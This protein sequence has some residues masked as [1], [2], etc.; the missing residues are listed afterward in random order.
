M[1]YIG[2]KPTV[3]NF[4]ICDAISVVNGQAAYTMQVGSVNVI[5]ESANHMIVSLNG[6]IQKPNS[7]FTVSGSTITF[8]SNLATG[9]VIDFIQ[10]LGNVLDLGVPSD[11]TVTSAKLNLTS[12]VGIGESSPGTLLDIKGSPGAN[13]RIT[14]N[15]SE[16]GSNAQVLGGIVIEN[17]GDSVVQISGRRESATDDGYFAIETQATGGSLTER[18]RIHSGGV[19]SAANGIALGVGTANTASN[20]LDDY[21]EGTFTPQLKISGSTTGITYSAQAGHYTKIGNRAIV[22][23]EI[24]LSAKGSNTG[25]V[26]LIGLPFTTSNDNYQTAYVYNDRVSSPNGDVQAYVLS[27]NTNIN[28]YQSRTDGTNNGNL[29]GNELNSNSYLIMFATYKTA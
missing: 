26:S 12:A 24:A 14:I 11:G 2:T 13:N 6:T 15:S 28:F 23:M 22:N 20:V 21:E 29:T 4:Q 9:D 7:S 17:Q 27:N 5:P 10:I 25:N 3:G 8:A 19:M 1:A 16:A 18:V